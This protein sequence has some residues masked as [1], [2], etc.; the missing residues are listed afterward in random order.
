MANKKIQFDLVFTAN[1]AEA[2]RQMKDLQNTLKD[3]GSG[4]KL[5]VSKGISSEILNASKAASELRTHLQ[6]ATNADT[7]RLN[8]NA[9]ERSLQSAGKSLKSYA[10]ELIKLGPEGTQSLNQIAN[11]ISNAEKPTLRLNDALDKMWLTMK[12]TARWQIST[13]ALNTMTGAIQSAYDYAQ[14]LN[15]SLN[16][17]RIVTNRSVQDMADFAKQ[18]NRVAQALSATTTEYTNASL[19]FTAIS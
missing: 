17:I 13:T 11:A 16:D 9:L 5:D 3:L 4:S 1:T 7:G 15:R 10:S 8:M 6:A 12:N 18:A 2:K 19:I 14:R